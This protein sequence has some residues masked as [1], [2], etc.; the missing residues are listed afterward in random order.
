MS[1]KRHS[2]KLFP[3]YYVTTKFGVSNKGFHDSVVHDFFLLLCTSAA[4]ACDV[5]TRS[6][7]RMEIRDKSFKTSP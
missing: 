7:V 2:F 4:H 1:L 5:G 6:S 3:Q